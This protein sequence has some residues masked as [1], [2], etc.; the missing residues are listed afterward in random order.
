MSEPATPNKYGVRSNEELWGLG[1]SRKDSLDRLFQHI[2]PYVR[3]ARR[4]RDMERAWAVVTSP[5]RPAA[6]SDAELLAWAAVLKK[7]KASWIRRE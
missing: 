1:I 2:D 3:H 6:A 7:R 4:R 5:G